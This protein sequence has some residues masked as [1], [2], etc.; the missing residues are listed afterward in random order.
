MRDNF[1]LYRVCEQIK[2]TFNRYHLTYCCDLK[3]EIIHVESRACDDCFSNV[4][5]RFLFDKLKDY[6][7]FFLND[8][9]GHPIVK[10]MVK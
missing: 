6:S 9:T 1:E 5:L 7:I 3:G 8:K 10:I 4:F 2:T